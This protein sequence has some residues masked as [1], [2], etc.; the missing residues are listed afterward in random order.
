MLKSPI[1]RLLNS[2]S[3][4]PTS[5]LLGLQ[6]MASHLDSRFADHPHTQLAAPLSAKQFVAL[7]QLGRYICM[8]VVQIQKL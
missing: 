2:N 6:K 1:I 5:S 3:K 8:D 7:E 4:V